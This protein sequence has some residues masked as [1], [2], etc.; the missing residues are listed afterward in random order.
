MTE[1]V[2]VS[3][4]SETKRPL[5]KSKYTI[6]NTKHSMEKFEQETVPDGYKMVSFDVK[7]LFTNVSLEKPINITLEIIYVK[8]STH[9]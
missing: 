4:H 3:S 8:K 1:F 7:S 6:D 2:H 5:S 9:K